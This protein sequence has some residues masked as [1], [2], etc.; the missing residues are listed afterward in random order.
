[1][2][3]LRI[4]RFESPAA[5]QLDDM[6][7]PEPGPGQVRVKVTAAGISLVDQLIASGRYQVRPPMPFIGGSE[8]AGV[9]DALGPDAPASLKVGD[10]VAGNVFPG[11]WAQQV[12]V[13]ADRVYPLDA[14]VS[15]TEAALLAVP[16]GTALY[17]LSTRGNLLPGETVFVLG[18]GGGVGYAAVQVARAL[19]AKVIAGAGTEARRQAALAAGADLVVDTRSADWKDQVK[20]MTPGGGVD[21]VLDPVGG[22]ATEAAFRT[23]GWGGRLLVIGFAAGEIGKL[24]ANL[25]LL[26]GAAMVGVD[27]RQFGERQPEQHR[28]NVREVLKMYAEGKLRPLVARE[29]PLEQFAEAMAATAD[30]ATV[31]RVVMRC[32]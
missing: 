11:V 6:P 26:K 16:Y 9:I 1:M 4:H 31:G 22:S 12:C 10:R 19:G 18:A 8:F 15:L 28:A 14:A 23:L 27:L 17:G 30:P 13:P 20:A 7:S 3:A 25:A 5:L 24:P 29:F 32:D 2:K 21:V